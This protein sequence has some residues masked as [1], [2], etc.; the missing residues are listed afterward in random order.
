MELKDLFKFPPEPERTWALYFLG[1]LLLYMY[2]DLK[3][4]SP[5]QRRKQE[6][7]SPIDSFSWLCTVGYT[8]VLSL[9]FQK[10][11]KY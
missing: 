3:H 11:Q 6:V 7:F 5:I 4:S 1:V 2:G 10:H 8:N 9:K